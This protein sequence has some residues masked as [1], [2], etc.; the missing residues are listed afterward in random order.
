[1]TPLGDLLDIPAF[2]ERRDVL[3][4]SPPCQ[5]FTPK[6]KIVMPD[7][8]AVRRDKNARLNR[9]ADQVQAAINAGATTT[10][11][12]A[13]E[14]PLLTDADLRETASSASATASGGLNCAQGR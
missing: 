3:M 8:H 12:L 11:A 5:P 4:T 14:L 1:M 9:L 2:L 13:S 7:Y 6:V 10:K